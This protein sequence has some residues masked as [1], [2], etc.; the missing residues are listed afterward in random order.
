MGDIGGGA[1]WK[2]RFTPDERSGYWNF[3]F[4]LEYD[5]ASTPPGPINVMD[6]PVPASPWVSGTSGPLVPGVLWAQSY[7]FKSLPVNP[8]AEGHHGRGFIR[9][10]SPTAGTSRYLKY[11]WP[12][13]AVRKQYFLKIGV[14]SPENWF[15]Y[16]DFYKSG[17]D[18][19]Y[20]MNPL[21]AATA[22]PN[23]SNAGPGSGAWHSFSSPSV[24][25]V[26]V[27]GPHNTMDWQNGPDWDTTRS[28][29]D[30]DLVT[31]FL[32]EA[33][34]DNRSAGR[35]IIGAIRYL[36]S[37]GLNSMYVEPMNLGGDGRDT[38]PFAAID[39]ADLGYAATGPATP[40]SVFNYSIRR[41][42]EWNIVLAFAMLKGMLVQFQLHEH[43]QANLGWL[44]Y[45][46]D[47]ATG[48]AVTAGI[49]PHSLT[50]ARR[51]YLKQMI[52]HFGCHTGIQWNLCEEN[53]VAAQFAVAQLR[54]MA[55]WIMLWD[56]YHDHPIAVHSNGN[57]WNLYKLIV[58]DLNANPPTPPAGVTYASWRY[59]P[60]L[61]VTSYYIYDDAPQVLGDIAPTGPQGNTPGHPG[62][63]HNFDEGTERLRS[64]LSLL[65]TFGD[66][67]VVAVDEPGE[68]KFGASGTNDQATV[69]VVQGSPTFM[70]SPEA[71]RRGALYDILFSGGNLEWYFGYGMEMDGFDSAAP[72]S[73]PD[74]LRA[75]G[76]GDVSADE[77]RSREE[78][79]AACAAAR[80]IMARVRFWDA[81]PADNI[82]TGEYD[83][84]MG[85]NPFGTGTFGQ[86][87]VYGMRTSTSPDAGGFYLIYYPNAYDSANNNTPR[88]LGA[89][90]VPGAVSPNL[91]AAAQYFSPLTGEEVQHQFAMYYTDLTN[92]LQL[93]AP[94]ASAWPSSGPPEDIVCLVTVF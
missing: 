62:W 38:H 5:H 65:G 43:E 12:G 47:P 34:D 69:G 2:L 86:A 71:K 81:S 28:T 84:A 91:A 52:A 48:D 42:R 13:L 57:S 88:S 44:D 23:G 17:K 45:D 51:L 67:V 30:L 94:P 56:G 70:S 39:L 59:R 21:A 26:H 29:V 90:A 8:N 58:D 15:G 20:E 32:T 76:G 87:Q 3:V 60:W 31:G 55:D 83:D 82:L 50:H 54:A 35:G 1:F 46:W 22:Y 61:D 36:S 53:A 41:A 72:T 25:T 89:L 49:V 19:R 78:L 92:P 27:G 68:W 77:F 24:G 80:R 64:E 9:S 6:T 75:F 18:L 63:Q 93:V 73:I 40:R 4:L 74:P 14:N 66:R 11:S 85:G 7:A 37:Q 33:L 16:R 79:W 10:E